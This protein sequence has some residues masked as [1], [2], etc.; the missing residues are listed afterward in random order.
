[1]PADAPSTR[2][3]FRRI[4]P[5]TTPAPMAR[6]PGRVWTDAEW[7]RIRRGYR[8][9]DMDEKWNVFTED[10]VVFLHRSWKGF[11]VF[12]ATFAPV[13]GGGRRIVSA[14]VEAGRGG[15][16]GSSADYD[17]LMLEL[18]LSGVVLGEPATELRRQLV[19][20]VRQAP[21]AADASAGAVRHSMLGLRSGS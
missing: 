21:G 3:S 13:G 5:I 18:V 4:L 17:C 15:L 7:E 12:E 16:H 2:E 9:Y 6:L 10:D 8:A 20:V 14:V 19:E 11:G 1:M